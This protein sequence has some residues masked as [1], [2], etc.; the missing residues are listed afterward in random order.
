MA[1]VRRIGVTGATGGLG[2]R[3]AARL[4]ERGVEQRLV[5]RDAARAPKLPNADVATIAGYGDGEGIRRALDGI[6]TLYFVSAA[7]DADRVGLHASVV[8]AAVA[9]G[10]E[11]IVYT[12]VVGAAPDA[13]FTFVRDHFHTEELVRA[14]GA[15]FTFLRHSLYIDFVP[16]LCSADGVI[17]GPAD[18]GRVAAVARDDIAD[19]T[20]AVLTGDGHEGQAYDV[21][22]AEAFSLAEA[23]EELSRVTGRRVAFEDETIEDAYA[24]RA[25]S[26][27]PKY[28]VDGWVTTYVAIARGEL[29]VVSDCVQRFL[30]RE[31]QRLGGWLDA[32]PESW[33]HLVLAP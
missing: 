11:R 30:D 9:A 18:D 21:T 23:A 32:N 17:R 13:T 10:V 19:V 24:S 16:L 31:P 5:V 15:P 8:E 26:G 29:E 4:A 2:G 28:I 25:S 7:E 20:V 3:V 14:S 22:G 6:G 33:R 12:S 27:A 1:G